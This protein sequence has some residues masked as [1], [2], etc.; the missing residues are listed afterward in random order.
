MTP[1]LLFCHFPFGKNPDSVREYAATH[2]YAGV[3]WALDSW[4]IMVARDRREQLLER[5]R[6]ASPVSSVHAP[7]TDLE[8]GHRDAEF[9]E[10]SLR[11]LMRYVEIAAELGA[12]HL[13]LHVGSYAMRPEELSWDT[14]IRNVG[15]LLEYAARRG[16]QVT[17]E[18]LRNGLTSSP[19]TFVPLLQ[20][21]GAPITFDHG[22]AHG[23]PWVHEGRG[24]V[25]EFL[26]AIPTPI[27]AAHLYYT[28]KNDAHFVPTSVGQMADALDTLRKRGCEFWVLE[29]HTRETLEQTRKI[30]DEYLDA[31]GRRPA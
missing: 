30:I 9:A 14:L 28:E 15:T 12:H 2:G 19:E 26:R 27:S 1:S 5:L 11:I 25:L 16:T 20:A 17:L 6:Q 23:S 13:N 4:R 22:H 29:L 7:Y 31:R 24:T 8:I 10:A 3:E 21:T 18:N